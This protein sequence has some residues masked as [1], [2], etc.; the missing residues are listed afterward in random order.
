MIQRP[1]RPQSIGLGFD[2]HRLVPARP[3]VLGGV[4]LP[5]VTTAGALIK[6]PT[7][8]ATQFRAAFADGVRLPRGPV[9]FSTPLPLRW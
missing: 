7:H 8:H 2:V 1:Q 9:T 4:T 3:C 5:L 6:D